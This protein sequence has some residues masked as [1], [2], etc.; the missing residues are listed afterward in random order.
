M[1]FM[2]IK[3]LLVLAAVILLPGCATI[4]KSS[5]EMIYIQSDPAGARAVVNGL[6]VG[7]TP[8]T[9]PTNGT[10]DQ[11]ITLSKDGYAPQTMFIT[12]SVGAG[13][14]IADIL[15]GFWPVVIDAATG[16]WKS[17]DQKAVYG[18]LERR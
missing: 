7:V 13:W 10:K 18:I 3:L 5:T 8:V 15:C 12:S 16:Q 4:L 9:Y 6:E 2:V 17:L 1:E 14:V 11:V